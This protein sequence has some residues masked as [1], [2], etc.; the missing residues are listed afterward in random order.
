[1]PV[2]CTSKRSSKRSS[3]KVR[4][5]SK[6]VGHKG[7]AKQVRRTSKTVGRKHSSR[8]KVMKGGKDGTLLVVDNKNTNNNIVLCD[9][10]LDI[11]EKLKA[12]GKYP[13]HLNTLNLIINLKAALRDQIYVSAPAET[14]TAIDNF[15]QNLSKLP[16]YPLVR[17]C[18]LKKN[19]SGLK[20]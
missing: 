11:A 12:S 10:D 9:E 16:G 1:M 15:Q 4:R 7:G 2:K 8:R 14:L 18:A 13:Q 3:R 17:K 20:I 19:Q 6:K 5:T